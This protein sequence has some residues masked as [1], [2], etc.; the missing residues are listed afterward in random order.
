MTIL[1][2]D[3]F[4]SDTVGAIAPGWTAVTG[5]WL[6]GTTTPVSGSN[7]FGNTSNVSGQ[8]AVYTAGT[9]QADQEFVVY[10]V[11][12]T[13]GSHDPMVRCDATGANGYI[14]TYDCVAGTVKIFKAVG[15]ANSSIGSAANPGAPVAGHVVGL[16]LRASGTTLEARVWDVTLGQSRPST[17]TLS[18]TDA[19]RA[20]GVPGLYWGKAA[21]GGTGAVDSIVWTDG[22]AAATA[23]TFTGPTSGPVGAAS[24]SFT[25]AAD[26]AITGTVTVTPS[27]NGGGG[28]FTPTS[29]AISAGTPSATFT[30]TPA[31]AGTKNITVTNNGGLNNPAGV[32]FSANSAATALTIS[33]AGTGTAGVGQT[34]TVGANGP[35]S[36]TVT[37]NLTA[38]PDGTYSPTSVSLTSGAPT[39]TSTYTPTTAGAKTLTATDAAS[40]LTAGTTTTTVGS[41]ATFDQTAVLFSPGNWNVGTSNAKTVND[42]AYFK[43]IFAGTSMVLT[44]DVSATSTP[45]PK[46]AYRVDGVGAWVTVDLAASITVTMPTETAALTT[47]FI[48]VYVAQTSEANSRWSPQNTAVILTGITLSTG[49]LSLPAS[50]TLKGLWFGDSIMCGVNTIGSSGDSTARGRE[51]LA[52]PY[53]VSEL[54]GVEFG[55]VAFGGQGW[56]KTGGGSVPVFPTTYSLLW[57]SGPAR[58]FAGLDYIVINQGQN[59]GAN[60]TTSQTTSVLNALIAATDR[61]TKI[62]VLEPFSGN[63]NANL[64]AG[65]A[66]TTAPSRITYINTFTGVSPVWFNNANSADAVHP[67]GFEHRNSITPKA[68]TALRPYLQPIKGA[69]AV[70]QARTVT[71]TLSDA[72]GIP[73][74]SLT[75]IKWSIFDQATPD[76]QAVA[77]DKGTGATT[78]GSGV[79][80]L[81]VYSTLSAGQVVWLT[82]SNS[83]GT[84]TQNPA[85][86]GFAGPVVLS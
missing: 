16:S 70:Q 59:D 1:Y 41:S 32:S 53:L 83:D 23:V 7:S 56:Q 65:I 73:R 75:G 15:G 9:S 68:V 12:S 77:V 61:R 5:T 42:G 85:A 71:L 31:S 17:P 66:A 67:Y 47:H 63:Q 44:F 46:I 8:L 86:M 36:G 11:N 74:A 20:A 6:V 62:I 26:G 40:A 57:G 64:I 37:V 10:Q 54:L 55:V 80:T 27:S 4:D 29:V 2:T 84:T 21:G 45:M 51:Q 33:T 81:S 14:M 69:A 28:T 3:N 25:V 18:V 43:T 76:A 22:T 50:R 34:A 38:T 58:S 52:Y 49:G 78:D 19:T 48:E 35:I 82:L 39:A 24:T 30:Y 60:A 72:T 13:N 79:L